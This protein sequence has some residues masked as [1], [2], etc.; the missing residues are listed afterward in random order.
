M[1]RFP[2]QLLQQTRLSSQELFRLVINLPVHRPS[3]N[4]TGEISLFSRLRRRS[5]VM[6]TTSPRLRRRL[7]DRSKLSSDAS[8][9]H[10][11]PDKS[12]SELKL[13][14]KVCHHRHERSHKTQH[15]SF[16]SRS[17]SETRAC[18]ET[19]YVCTTCPGRGPSTRLT[20]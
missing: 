18:H 8:A 4:G 16:S 13:N 11:R 20:V 1:I 2:K 10:G 15:I 14:V 9:A 19:K 17:R 5:Q 3:S 6:S 7:L 12:D